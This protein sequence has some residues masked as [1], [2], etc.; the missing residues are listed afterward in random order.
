M[1][2]FAVITFDLDGAESTIYNK[3]KIDLKKINIEKTLSKKD[4][5]KEITL[6]QNVYVGRFSESDY[7]SAKELRNYLTQELTKIFNKNSTEGKYFI[8]IGNGWAW[9]KGN[10]ELEED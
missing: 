6:P 9:K 5:S 3:I 10:I 8:L 4:R 1:S 7:K 2:F